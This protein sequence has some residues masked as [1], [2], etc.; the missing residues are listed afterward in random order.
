VDT[1]GRGNGMELG[2]VEGG[3]NHNKDIFCEEKIYIFN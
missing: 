1:E 2:G 3:K